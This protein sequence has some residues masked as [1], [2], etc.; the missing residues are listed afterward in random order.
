MSSLWKF[1]VRKELDSF[2]GDFILLFSLPVFESLRLST[3]FISTTD[4]NR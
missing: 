4:T 2:P 1:A 3:F